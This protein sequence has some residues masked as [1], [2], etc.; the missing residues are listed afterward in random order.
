MKHFSG[1]LILAVM[2]LFVPQGNADPVH[3]G[4]GGIA[5]NPAIFSPGEE[6]SIG[7]TLSSATQVTSIAL[8]TLTHAGGLAADA[9]YSA[10]LTGPG[11]VVSW[12]P[13]GVLSAGNYV[14]TADV[15]SCGQ[16]CFPLDDFLAVNFYLPLSLTQLGGTINPVLGNTPGVGWNLVGSTVAPVPEPASAALLSGGLLA[17]WA[18]ARRRVRVNS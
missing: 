14:Y 16:S 3:L 17:V 6:L 5:T 7:F 4:I 10:M 9:T 15:L 13:G 11:G 2:S 18:A 1:L 8:D 12:A